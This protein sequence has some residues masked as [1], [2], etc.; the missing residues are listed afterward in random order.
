M[1]PNLHMLRRT[2]ATNPV[3]LC[4]CKRSSSVL[5]R[6]H[7]YLRAL[8]G[9]TPLSALALLHVNHDANI[10]IDNVL[11]YLPKRKKELWSLIIFVI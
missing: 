6:V 7:T 3:T 4:K 11:T 5:K 1:Y 8:I 2:C 9:Q 10:D